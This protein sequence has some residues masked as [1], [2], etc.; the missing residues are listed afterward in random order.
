[1]NSTV[2]SAKYFQGQSGIISRISQVQPAVSVG[3]PTLGRAL[4]LPIL[5]PLEFLRAGGVSHYGCSSWGR[6]TDH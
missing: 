6:E 3:K 2:T 4:I 1:M 5:R